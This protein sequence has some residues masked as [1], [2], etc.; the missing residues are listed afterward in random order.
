MKIKQV[1]ALPKERTYPEFKEDTQ[2]MHKKCGVDLNCDYQKQAFDFLE[3]T[4]SKLTIIKIGLDSHNPEQ[5]KSERIK[6]HIILEKGKNKC[7]FDFWGASV[8]ACKPKRKHSDSCYQRDRDEG[9]AINKASNIMPYDVLAGMGHHIEP[10][11]DDFCAEFGYGPFNNEEEFRKAEDTH[12]ACLK[13]Q[14]NLER[15]Y[16]QEE[17]EMLQEI[18]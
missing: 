14:A 8:E 15:L 6:F 1:S 2:A 4:G 17:L 9:I 10:I 16:N 18:A 7:S 3:K 11:F 12:K 5:W 13:E